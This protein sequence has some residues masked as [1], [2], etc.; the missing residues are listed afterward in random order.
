VIFFNPVT[1]EML[2]KKKAF[3]K[4]EKERGQRCKKNYRKSIGISVGLLNLLCNL[5]IIHNKRSVF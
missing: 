5:G 1:E 2:K 4:E 3:A